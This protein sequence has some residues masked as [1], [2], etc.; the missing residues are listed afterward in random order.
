VTALA[1]VLSLLEQGP[2]TREEIADTCRIPRASLGT[3]I[4]DLRRAG[5]IAKVGT[6]QREIT[7]V[8]SFPLYGLSSHREAPA[9]IEGDLNK[10]AS[11]WVRAA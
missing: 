4:T 9:Q 1:D 7:V 10:A 8:R 11:A 6:I 3:H 2:A 5:L